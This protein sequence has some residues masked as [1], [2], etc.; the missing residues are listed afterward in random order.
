M[1]DFREWLSDNL[2]YILLGLAI[3]AVLL[4]LFFGI[5]FL[6]STFGDDSKKEQKVTE[7]QKDTEKE[8]KEEKKDT[9]DDQEKEPEA[10]AT[11]APTEEP[12]QENPLEKNEYPT[13]NALI[14]QYYTALA[15]RMW[16]V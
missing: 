2:R 6:T 8:Q 5:R 3:I 4:V 1:D 16:I 14:Q 7:Q 11:P 10:T 12:K 13:V 9:E 15:Q